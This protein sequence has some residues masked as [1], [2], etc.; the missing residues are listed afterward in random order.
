MKHQEFTYNKHTT[1]L[2]STKI[3]ISEIAL[4]QMV[5]I[6]RIRIGE[7]EEQDHSF[8]GENDTMALQLAPSFFF[9]SSIN[10]L[11]FNDLYINRNRALL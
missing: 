9:T 3:Q 10:K 6:V 5:V 11:V 4:Q 1:Y 2:S 7:L 8:K